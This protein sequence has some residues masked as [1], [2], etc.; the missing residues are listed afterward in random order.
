MDGVSKV[1]SKREFRRNDVSKKRATT[2]LTLTSCVISEFAD[3]FLLTGEVTQFGDGDTFK[4]TAEKFGTISIR[5][6]GVD[7]PESKGQNWP[8]QPYSAEAG[9]FVRDMVGNRDVMVR[10]KG[11][12]TLEA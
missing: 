1:G 3:G 5:F 10:M 12:R 8:A 4:L 7:T 9:Q 11:D 6:H 2:L